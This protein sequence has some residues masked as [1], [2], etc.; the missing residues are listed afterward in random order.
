MGARSAK[1]ENQFVGE[2][3]FDLCLR[4]GELIALQEKLGVGPQVLATRFYVGEWT[5]QDVVET[6]RLALIGGGMTQKDAFDLVNRNVVSGYLGD[7]AAIAGQTI[8][9]AISGVEDEDMPG[10]AGAPMTGQMTTHQD[11]LV[12]E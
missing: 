5:V 1:L 4:I 3:H 9:A 11:E 10:E 6:I 12:G 8:Y 2:G 7:Y